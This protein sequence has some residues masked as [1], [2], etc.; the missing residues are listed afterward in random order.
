VLD[1]Y[2]VVSIALGS[3][4]VSSF[5]SDLDAFISIK[6]AIAESFNHI[7]QTSSATELEKEALQSRLAEQEKLRTV[8]QLAKQQV[9]TQ[10][11]EKQK[12][13]RPQGT[14]LGAPQRHRGVE[15]E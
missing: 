6:R 4:G 11:Q 15:K 8:A 1:G 2:S 12:L 7:R 9:V 5:F 3:R 14:S 10:E 13:P